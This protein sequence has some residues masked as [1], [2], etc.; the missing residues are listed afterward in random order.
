M[1]LELEVDIVDQVKPKPK[2]CCTLISFF[3]Q[4]SALHEYQ[5][6]NTV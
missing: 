3:A 4:G 1:V 5:H 6:F 2:S